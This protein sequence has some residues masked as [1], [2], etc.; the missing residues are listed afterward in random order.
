M[1]KCQCH[2]LGCQRFQIKEKPVI[3][4]YLLYLLVVHQGE[5]YFMPLIPCASYFNGNWESGDT[6]KA[7]GMGLA[8]SGH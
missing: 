4:S 1:D 6:Q 8:L 3:K 2:G 5:K 7:L